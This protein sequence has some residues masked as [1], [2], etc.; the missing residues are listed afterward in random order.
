MKDE[1]KRKRAADLGSCMLLKIAKQPWLQLHIARL[2]HTMD[3][4]KCCGDGELF[5]DRVQYFVNPVHILWSRIKFLFRHTTVV[6]TVLDPTS[7]P[8][9]HFEDQLHRFHPSH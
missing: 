9:F 2:V 1:K 8:D 6:N 3:I 7:D 4:T 5:R